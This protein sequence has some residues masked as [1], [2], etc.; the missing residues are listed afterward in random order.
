ME[1]F[2]TYFHVRDGSKILQHPLYLRYNVLTPQQIADEDLGQGYKNLQTAMGGIM[3]T[4]DNMPIL[5]Y[6]RSILDIGKELG[7]V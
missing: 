2:G 6:L 7:L 4:N 3:L 1:G 5:W